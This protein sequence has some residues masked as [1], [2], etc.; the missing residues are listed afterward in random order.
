[1]VNFFNIFF[2]KTTVVIKAWILDVDLSKEVVRSVPMWIQLRNLHIKYWVSIAC[3]KLL[4]RLES[5]LKFNLLKL[6]RQ[7]TIGKGCCMLDW[8]LKLW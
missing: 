7:H 2:D 6:I 3:S 4:V 1:M 8:L 5:L